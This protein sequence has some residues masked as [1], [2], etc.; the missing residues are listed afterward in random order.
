MADLIFLV[1]VGMVVLVPTVVIVVV[2]SNR[3]ALRPVL[4]D[5][6]P[7][8]QVVSWIDGEAGG[9]ETVGTL[10]RTDNAYALIEVDGTRRF[11]PRE[12]LRLI[13][14]RGPAAGSPR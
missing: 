8:S 9:T 7:G 6:A 10:V 4:P 14:G 1:V 2:V 13:P 11:V 12:S 5:F 3:R